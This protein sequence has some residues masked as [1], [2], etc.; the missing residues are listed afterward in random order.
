M[1]VTFVCQRH[2]IVTINDWLR[3]S[4]LVKLHQDLSDVIA[5]FLR[6]ASGGVFVG[7]HSGS[8]TWRS[9]IMGGRQSLLKSPVLGVLCKEEFWARG[10]GRN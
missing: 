3:L 7:E 5:I 1:N 10:I 9:T 8:G 2:Q 6:V 4:S